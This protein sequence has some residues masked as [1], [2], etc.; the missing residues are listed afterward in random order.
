MGE[1]ILVS[2][3][4]KYILFVNRGANIN[5]KETEDAFTALGSEVKIVA[6]DGDPRNEVFMVPA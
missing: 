6:V 3:G 5:R 2:S 4:R 1:P